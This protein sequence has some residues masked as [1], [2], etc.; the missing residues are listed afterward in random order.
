MSF[1]KKIDITFFFDMQREQRDRELGQNTPFLGK[2]KKTTR[3]STNVQVF[4][5]FF[6]CFQLV[7][8]AK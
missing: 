4:F 7:I 2:K 6:E 1:K 5:N 3:S 8:K